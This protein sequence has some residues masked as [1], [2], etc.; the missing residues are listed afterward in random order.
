MLGTLEMP[1]IEKLLSS[2]LVGRIGCFDGDQVYIVPISYAYDGKFVYCHTYEG[3]KLEIMRKN[4]KVCFEVDDMRNM[5]NWQ[6]VI[7]WGEFEELKDPTQR[8]KAL[9]KLH[10]RIL[11]MMASETV[12]LSSSWPFPPD[13]M[14]KIK[15]V[16][17]RI[18]VSKKTGRF[19]KPIGQTLYHS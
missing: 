5:A 10:D 15:G 9:V 11:P 4:P 1:E 8:G 2:Q 14:S 3:L 6:S 18:L 13:E 17:F 19:E 7:A 16:A 12:R